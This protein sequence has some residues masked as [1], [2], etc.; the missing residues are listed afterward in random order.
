MVRVTRICLSRS[1]CIDLQAIANESGL[2]FISVKGPELLD[3]FVGESEKA[4]RRVF[5]LAQNAA[6]CV[7]FFDELDGLC[8]TR[9][10][11]QSSQVKHRL[12]S[13]QSPPMRMF[14]ATDL[15]R[16]KQILFVG[17]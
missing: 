17:F 12:N 9:S 2:N 4:V 13:H 7:I 11:N 8:S 15:N 6:P 14:E 16:H 1:T 3:K 10:D 5:A